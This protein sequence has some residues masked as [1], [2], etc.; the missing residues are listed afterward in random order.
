[1]PGRSS[2]ARAA[3]R[4]LRSLLRLFRAN[5]S[6]SICAR[7][8]W[9][10]AQY[11]VVQSSIA[12]CA[13][14][15][16]CFGPIIPVPFAR[17]RLGAWRNITLYKQ[18]SRAAL[19]PTLV[20]GQSFLC[21]LRAN[22]LAHGAISRCTNKAVA[23]ACHRRYWPE[24]NV[25]ASKARDA[26][27][28]RRSI[29]AQTQNP[30]QTPRPNINLPPVPHRPGGSC[31]TCAFSRP[32]WYGEYANVQPRAQ[33]YRWHRPGPAGSAPAPGYPGSP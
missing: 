18:A 32:G 29:C 22:A 30:R 10:M 21:H 26:P 24:T 17:E 31:R 23:R 14:S 20:S 3:H 6:C 13:R 25:G 8:P 7:T 19:A 4:E 2:A 12:S 5:H 33:R 16:A 15:Y 1:M 11:H 27:R 28:G 9:R